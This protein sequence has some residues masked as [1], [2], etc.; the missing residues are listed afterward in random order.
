MFQAPAMF[1]RKY[2]DYTVN[3]ISQIELVFSTRS[4]NKMTKSM[5][6]LSR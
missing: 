5:Y 6:K 2:Q 1:I 4:N 3:S